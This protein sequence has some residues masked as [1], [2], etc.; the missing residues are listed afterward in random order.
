MKR[1]ICFTAEAPNF[2]ENLQDCSSTRSHVLMSVLKKKQQILL[3][4]HRLCFIFHAHVEPNTLSIH[5]LGANKSDKPSTL[6]T[7]T[8]SQSLTE[9]SG[10]EQRA[11]RPHPGSE[12]WSSSGLESSVFFLRSVLV[13]HSDRNPLTMYPEGGGERLHDVG[14]S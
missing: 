8:Q 11:C 9:Q 12:S 5:F 1:Q 2:E 7:R 6:A 10:E 4:K 13:V 3:D 14:A